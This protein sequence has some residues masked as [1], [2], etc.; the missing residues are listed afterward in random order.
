MESKRKIYKACHRRTIE[1][2]RTRWKDGRIEKDIYGLGKYAIRG[3][4]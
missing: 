3:C 4:E 2:F 1:R